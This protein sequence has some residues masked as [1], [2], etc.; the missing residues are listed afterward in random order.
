MILP[1]LCE[2][3]NLKFRMIRPVT[4]VGSFSLRGRNLNIPRPSPMSLCWVS[5][6]RLIT[7]VLYAALRVF[8]AFCIH[9][10][11]R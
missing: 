7:K 9:P 3:P 2:G 11:V 1:A 10:M 8:I 4:W 5:L 6:Y